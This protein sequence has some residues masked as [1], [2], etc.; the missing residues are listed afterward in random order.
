M[1]FVRNKGI[2]MKNID[3]E[4]IFKK[5]ILGVAFSGKLC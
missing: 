2:L 4:K 3:H 1:L 5:G